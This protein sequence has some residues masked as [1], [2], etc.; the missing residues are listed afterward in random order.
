MCV[1]YVQESIL[2]AIE[3]IDRWPNRILSSAARKKTDKGNLRNSP[4]SHSPGSLRLF[5]SQYIFPFTY[6]YQEVTMASLTRGIFIVGAKRTAFGTFGGKLANKTCVDLQEIA[7]KAALSAA[8]VNPELVD[9]VIIGNVLSCSSVDAPYISRH[10]SLRCG[11]P[12]PTPALTSIFGC[13][14]TFISS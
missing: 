12:I 6:H 8:N 13:F 2:Q 9:S 11:I 1:F 3:P 10:V 5:T 7:A 14:S 4:S